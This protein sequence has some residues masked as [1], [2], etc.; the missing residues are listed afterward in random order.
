MEGGLAAEK[1]YLLDGADEMARLDMQAAFYDPQHDVAMLRP[2][3]AD[4]VLDA[5][6]G[7][8]AYS[9]AIARAVPRGAVVGV[10][11]EAKYV[12]YAVRKAAAEGVTN[13]TFRQGD[14]CALPFADAEFDLVW[15]KHVLQWLREPQKAVAEFARVVKPGGRVVCANFDGFVLANWPVEADIQAQAELWFNAAKRDLGFDGYV[16]RKLATMFHAAGLVDIRVTTEVD[17][18]FGGFGRM[19]EIQRR[20]WQ[21]Q[22]EAAFEFSVR[23]FGSRGR[24]AEY[25][26][27]VSTYLDR[28][29]GY[30]H[31]TMFYVEGCRR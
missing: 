5:G 30:R 28:A 10:D 16:G 11:R 18:M 4:R 27:R 23:V 8:A 13:A 22:M 26:E 7:S 3:V 31:T 24:A 29:D 2:E 9:R 19:S 15:S 14:I 12:D 6:C 25:V 1:Q 21:I 17:R 20:N